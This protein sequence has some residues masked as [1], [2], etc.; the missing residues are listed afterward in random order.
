MSAA[1]SADGKLLATAS[2]DIAAHLFDVAS[3]KEI[4]RLAHDGRVTDVAF[5]P[6][7]KLLATACG[8]KMARLFDVA[9]REKVASLAHDNGVQGVAFSPDGKLLATAAGGKNGF[10]GEVRL[11][12]VANNKEVTRL[13]HDLVAFNVAF[14]PDGHLL[15]S[16][17]SSKAMVFEVPGG[18]EIGEIGPM[19]S[20]DAMQRVAFSPD[21]RL[22]ATSEGFGDRGSARLI[23]LASGKAIAQMTH[24]RQV[25]SATFSPDGLTLATASDDRTARLWHVFLTTQALVDAAKAR[26]ARCLTQAQ[27]KQ[28]FLSPAPPL[29]CIERRLWPYHSDNWQAWL[30]AK[31]A[32]KDAPLPAD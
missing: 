1:F 27:R 5:S 10:D 17:S 8:D 3:G 21:G 22:L 30:A 23:E 19:T 26:A 20:D 6:D 28:Y 11:F 7:G 24:Q 16:S 4:A 25:N 18:K 13:P 12:G 9:S 14:S 2:Y 31:K 15:A 32:S 29:W